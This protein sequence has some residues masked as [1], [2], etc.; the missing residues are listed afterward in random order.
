M[1]DGPAVVPARHGEGLQPLGDSPQRPGQGV[2]AAPLEVVDEVVEGAIVR[3]PRDHALVEGCQR[4]GVGE[5]EEGG[6]ARWAP[7]PHSPGRPADSLV[8]RQ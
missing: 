8:G 3:V 5:S 6:R 4:K 2:R 1:E 7:L